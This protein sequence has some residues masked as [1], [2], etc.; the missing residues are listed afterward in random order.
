MTLAQLRYL[1]AIVDA[2]LNITVA[3]ERVNATQ[4]GLSKQLRQLEEQLELRLFVRRSRNLERLTPAGEEIVRRARIIAGEA[5]DIRKFALSQRTA[6]DGSLHIE[7][8]HIQALFVLPDALTSLRAQFP[9]LDVT[10]GFAADVDDASERFRSVDLRMFSTD[11]SRPTGEITIPLYHW[12]PVAIVKTD[13]PIARQSVPITLEML[14]AFPLITYDHSKT[15]PLSMARTFVEAGLSPR[16]AFTVR[17]ANLIK[18]S[19]RSGTGIG[20]LAEMAVDAEA[21]RDLHVIPLAGLLPR[22]TT[23][24]VL[25]RDCVLRDCLVH[26]LSS[27]SGLTP[28][29]IRR[30]IAGDVE[31]DAVFANVRTWSDATALPRAK[32][33]EGARPIHLVPTQDLAGA[34]RSAISTPTRQYA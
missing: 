30:L 8:T 1:L 12:N 4:P 3:A 22:C 15:A 20:L 10:L 9:T 7:T 19:V 28:L 34:P 31:P 23:W 6:Q 32:S 18:A 11:G 13:H 14:A 17:E 5:D 25:R 21:D 2:G 27:L 16:F 29:V 24:A 33:W 26:L